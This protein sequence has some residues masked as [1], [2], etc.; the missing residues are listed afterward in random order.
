[1]AIEATTDL[2]MI[3]DGVA[4][5]AV[6]G[7]WLEV[8]S[9]ATREVVGRVP[10]GS[11]ADVDLAVSAARRAFVDGRWSRATPAERSVV[12][13]RLADLIDA[14]A[15][16]IARLE[17]LQTGSAYK[18]RRDS[19]LV[20]A[21]DNLRFFAGAARCLE[22][23]AA[24]ETMQGYTSFRR[25]APVRVICQLET[26]DYPF[27][28]AIWK[29]AP[30]LAAGNSVVL[31]PA[32]AT[33]LTTIRLAQLALEAGLPAGVLNVVT[34]LGDTVG[35]TMAAHRDVDLISLTG[36]AATGRRIQ[37]AAGTPARPSR[38]RR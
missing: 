4:A 32:S 23:G 37:I 24:G 26:C 21:S 28:M 17:T 25:R 8:H 33:P 5:D 18:L 10:A 22:G 31:K 27:W 16:D 6:G 38:A 1:M 9:P 35:A 30:A 15:D 3:V 20:F 34:G 7:G 19:D 36:D 13:N 14:A 11:P 29:V 2:P 12:L